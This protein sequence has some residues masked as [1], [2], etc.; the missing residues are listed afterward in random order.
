MKASKLIE[1]LQD[2][3]ENH[4]DHEVVIGKDAK[5]AEASPCCGLSVEMWE[6]STLSRWKGSVQEGD[7]PNAILLWPG[8]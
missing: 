4:G 8:G 6:S 3:I 2:M 5:G 7:K 1:H